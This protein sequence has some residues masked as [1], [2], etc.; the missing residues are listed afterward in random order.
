MKLIEIQKALLTVL[1]EAQCARQFPKADWIS[2][3]RT[4]MLDAVNRLRVGKRPVD[5]ATITGVERLALGHV[6]Y[7]SKFALYC[8]ELVTAP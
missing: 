2:M 3:E 1:E 4:A 5:L 8:A 7:S 6:D